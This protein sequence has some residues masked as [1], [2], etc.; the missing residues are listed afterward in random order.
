MTATAERA[1]FLEERRTGVGGSD[2]AALD[3]QTGSPYASPWSVWATK[4]GLARPDEEPSD[5]MQLGLDLEPLI[6]AWFHRRTGLHVAG[7]QTFARHR[8]AP[9]AMA[10][11]DGLVYETEPAGDAEPLG[12]LESK[13]TGE[14]WDQPPAHYRAQ[15]QWQLHVS[16]LDHGWL[17][18]L[19]L[20]FGR[21]RFDVFEIAADRT[22]QRRLARLADR[23]W[24]DHVVTGVA[25]P[26]D[27][28]DATGRA[29]LAAYG[30]RPTVKVPVVAFDDA[31]QL[32]DEFAEFKRQE[33]T[34]AELAEWRGNEIR[35]RF[36]EA[37][38][39]LELDEAPSEGMIDGE[40][41]ISWRS[42]SESRIDT[43]AVRA[44]HG[45]R[46]DRRSIKRVLRLHGKRA[47]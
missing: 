35:A 40:L 22:E 29:I 41:A 18:A 45:D 10:H 6:A 5:A 32:V 13:F 44:D 16:G 3:P 34:A 42:Q 19:M 9:W 30:H 28:H 15:V 11:L 2:I 27:A 12:V 37:A 43:K 26:P 39:E 38:A 24:H 23:F 33:A 4:V 17:A 20:P 25:P 36:G 47:R 21:P 1:A 46:Y 7:A 31:R 8:R 14:T